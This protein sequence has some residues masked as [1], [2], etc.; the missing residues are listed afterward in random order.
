[1]TGVLL[2]EGPAAR[3]MRGGN[4]MQLYGCVSACASLGKMRGLLFLS[5]LVFLI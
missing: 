2:K 5:S 3:E 1:M 4:E